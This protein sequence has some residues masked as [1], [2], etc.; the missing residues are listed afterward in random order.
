[1]AESRT[2]KGGSPRT[3]FVYHFWLFCAGAVILLANAGRHGDH[4]HRAGSGFILLMFAYPAAILYAWGYSQ[5]KGGEI[6]DR[7]ERASKWWVRLTVGVPIG[8][9]ILSSLLGF[10]GGSG[11]ALASVA[12][13]ALI[14]IECHLTRL[15]EPPGKGAEKS[16]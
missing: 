5:A 13:L 8:V 3:R 12:Y 16:A 14:I 10:A 15:E 4:H 6:F 1:M 11:V 9:M 7:S 2:K